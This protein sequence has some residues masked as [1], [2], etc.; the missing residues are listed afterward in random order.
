MT[1]VTDTPGVAE[2]AS[3]FPL[4]LQ[5]YCTRL[6]MTDRR[7]ELI[8]G[9]EYYERVAGRMKDT[10]TEYDKRFAAFANLPA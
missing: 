10:A 2:T 7:V 8:G 5:E 3:E 1:K 6:S 4:S 9:F